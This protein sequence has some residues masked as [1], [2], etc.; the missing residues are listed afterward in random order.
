MDVRRDI[1]FYL[2]FACVLMLTTASPVMALQDY[3]FTVE[4]PK[5]IIFPQ[6]SVIESKKKTR[7]S[8]LTDQISNR[9]NYEIYEYIRIVLAEM[10]N[11]YE[12]E[13]QRAR[14]SAS[15]IDDKKKKQKLYRWSSNALIYADTLWNVFHGIDHYSQ[16]QTYTDNNHESYILIDNYPVVIT[17]PVINEQKTLEQQI[18]NAVCEQMYCDMDLINKQS[19]DNQKRIR[20][21]GGWKLQKDR[22]TFYT[23]TGLHFVFNNIEN[24]KLKQKVS[25]KISADLNLIADTLAEIINKGVFVDWGYLYLNQIPGSRYYEL[26][27]N[28]FGD[29]LRL[30]VNTIQ[31]LNDFP[32]IAVPWLRER[33]SKARKEFYFNNADQFLD[34]IYLN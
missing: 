13:A 25:L 30:T 33:I 14:E 9:S 16:L 18:I 21:R 34:D 4:K 17:S 15:Y 22:Y 2:S 24:K 8:A 7:L 32:E 3:L 11:V 23:Y 27:L 20:V 31:Y 19:H 28:P 5:L 1:K 29:K 6:T 12:E 10:I 26:I